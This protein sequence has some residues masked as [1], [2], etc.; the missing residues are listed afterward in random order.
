MVCRSRRMAV[1]R[2]VRFDES[3]ADTVDVDTD[4]EAERRSVKRYLPSDDTE[5]S[6]DAPN[7][8]IND[9][10]VVVSEPDEPQQSTPAPILPSLERHISASAPVVD[11]S[12]RFCHSCSRQH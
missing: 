3:V 9:R 11:L 2:S 5:D 4:S 8:E 1:S 7:F 12:H 6:D 10:P